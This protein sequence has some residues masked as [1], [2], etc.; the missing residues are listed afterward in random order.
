MG[1]LKGSLTEKNLLKAFAGESQA[2]NRYTYFSKIAKKEGYEQI[3][4]I[5]LE[6][7][8]QEK[9]HAKIFFNFLEGGPI[10]ITATYPAGIIGITQENLKFASLGEKEEWEIIYPEFSRIAKEEGFAKIA[11]SFKLISEIEA[12]HEKRYFKLL[13]NIEKNQVF[14]KDT[15]VIWVCRECGYHHTGLKSLE[16]CPVCG[17]PQAY[18]EIKN[19]NY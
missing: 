5:F 16:N 10:E 6:T 15:P 14:K 1:T 2:R 18:F 12:E 9:T 19:S 13:Q 8:E 11:T 17:H 4:S 3:S 7:A